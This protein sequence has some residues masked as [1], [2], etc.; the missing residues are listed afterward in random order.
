MKLYDTFDGWGCGDGT[1]N[2]TGYD[3]VAPSD[4]TG[5]GNATSI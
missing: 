1:I 3:D 2:G 5:D 4:G